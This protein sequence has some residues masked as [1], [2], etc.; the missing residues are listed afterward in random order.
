M[1]Q[2]SSTPGIPSAA[3]DLPEVRPGAVSVSASI[4]ALRAEFGPAIE[5]HLVSCG[6]SI[7]YV[8]KARS[9]DVLAWLRDSP[10]SGSTT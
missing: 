5:R 9:H 7:V 4:P 10:P 6:D 3:R 8:S 1:T 2:P